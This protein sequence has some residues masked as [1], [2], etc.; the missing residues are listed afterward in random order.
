MKRVFR[1]WHTRWSLQR[2]ALRSRVA[3]WRCT[4]VGHLWPAGLPPQWAVAYMERQL[5][6]MV[7]YRRACEALMA[8]Q[9][10][11]KQIDDEEIFADGEEEEFEEELI[12]FEKRCVAWLK[13][14]EGRAALKGLKDGGIVHVRDDD[15]DEESVG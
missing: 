9:V 7:E 6:I 14:P 12:D 4:L 10:M 11:K 5:A 13:T 8:A 1:Q 3:R 15:E 2:L